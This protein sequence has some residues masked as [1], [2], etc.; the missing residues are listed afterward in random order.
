MVETLTNEA[1]IH[2]AP[3]IAGCQTASARQFADICMHF[4]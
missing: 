4:D 3:A 1:L 2:E